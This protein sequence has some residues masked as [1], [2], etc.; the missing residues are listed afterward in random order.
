MFG[1]GGALLN[2]NLAN[3]CNIRVKQLNRGLF[4]VEKLYSKAGRNQA[5]AE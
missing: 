2:V 5:L 3:D 1:G 4:L